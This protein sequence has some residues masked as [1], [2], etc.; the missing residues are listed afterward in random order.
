MNDVPRDA[1]PTCGRTLAEHELDFFSKAPLVV[2]KCPP[3]APELQPA[4]IDPDA[5]A[6]LPVAPAVNP[7]PP[8]E[9]D[10]VT[11]ADLF[12]KAIVLSVTLSRPGNRKKVSS[13][14]VEVDADKSLV[15]VSKDLLDSKEYQAIAKKHGDIRKYVYQM[16]MPCSILGSGRYLLPVVSVELLDKRLTEFEAEV[17]GLVNEACVAYPIR[18][19]ESR[20]RLSVLWNATDYPPVEV[21]RSG[22]GI[23]WRYDTWGVPGQLEN[24]SAAIF[25]RESERAKE[26]VQEAAVEVTQILGQGLLACVDH[27]LERLTPG[28]DGKRKIFRDSTVT[29]FLEFLGGLSVKNLAGNA[30]L[31]AVAEQ[32]RRILNGVDP[33]TLRDSG[34][35][36]DYVATKMQEVKARLSEIAV[37]ARPSRMIVLSDD[38][39]AA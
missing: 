3:G 2:T 11:M 38:E 16:A 25:E 30:D 35:I 29:N 33:Q 5:F 39:T 12:S 6:S 4:E 24:I 31:E 17:G 28:S 27:M 26:R 23:S 34:P 37:V 14:L 22:F 32:S 18:V 19:E 21:Y 15:H 9:G 10:P 1:C 7:Q 8:K 20:A 36:R 13:G